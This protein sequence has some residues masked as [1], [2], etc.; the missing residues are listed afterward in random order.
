MV[1]VFGAKMDM[2]FSPKDLGLSVGVSGTVFGQ[3]GLDCFGKFQDELL[4]H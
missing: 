2:H 3:F 4:D 1:V